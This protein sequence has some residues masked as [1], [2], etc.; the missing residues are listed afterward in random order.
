MVSLER[1]ALD[2]TY[3]LYDSNSH[4][5]HALAMLTLTPILLN[6]AYAA[7]TIQTREAVY[8]EMWA[9]QMACEALN[10]VLKEWIQQERPNLDL[11]SGYGF[12]S[13]HSQWMGYFASFLLCHFTFRHQFVSTGYRILDG[14]FK[15]VLYSAI[16]AWSCAVA[17]SRYYL[18]YHTSA[19][20][21]WGFT[22]GILFGFTYYA[23]VELIPARYPNSLLGRARRGVL[24]SSVFTWF[25]IRDGW[26]VWSD[27]GLDAQYSEWRKVW[28]AKLDKKTL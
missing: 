21:V 28:N 23:A 3:V 17:Y 16:V 7:L 12:P 2:L 20:V 14:L 4:T 26:A 19:Q 10:W 13:S 22:I 15:L 24:S 5:S 1:S 18:T 11:G 27:G 25:R 8:L 6:P 9:G